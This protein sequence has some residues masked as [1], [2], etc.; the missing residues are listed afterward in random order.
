MFREAGPVIFSIGFCCVGPLLLIT[1]GI[2]IGRA[3]RLGL[4]FEVRRRRQ[5]E[6]RYSE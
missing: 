2:V 4:P 3:T 6:R 1:V 5:A